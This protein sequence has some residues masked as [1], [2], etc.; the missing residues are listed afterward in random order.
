MK[1]NCYRF[2]CSQCGEISSI[3]VFIKSN[4]EISYGRARHKSDKF[5]YHKLS[6]QYVQQKLRELSLVLPGQVPGQEISRMLDHSNP[7]TS[8][9]N[10]FVAGGV[11]FEPTTPNLG[12]WCSI[13]PKPW[14][15]GTSH[16]NRDLGIRPELP[17]QTNN[18]NRR[19]DI[20]TLL[21]IGKPVWSWI[22]NI[23]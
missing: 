4:G 23:F 13:R 9:I 18:T 17:A 3:Q 6:P 15:S 10:G 2:E 22:R 16:L 7:K 5:Y 19:I 8:P 14:L 21:T 12:G 11:G 20:N 1:I